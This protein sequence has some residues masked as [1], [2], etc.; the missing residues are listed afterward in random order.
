M[1]YLTTLSLTLI[2]WHQMKA[3]NEQWWKGCG[4]KQLWEL[5]TLSQALANLKVADVIY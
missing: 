1:V 5:P 2:T 3:D 4:R